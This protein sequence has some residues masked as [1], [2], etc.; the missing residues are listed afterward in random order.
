MAQSKIEWTEKSW[1]PIIGCSKVSAGCKNCY[2]ERMTYRI[3]NM[4][5]RGKYSGKAEPYGR[6]INW[7][8][9]KGNFK[10]FNGKVTLA[11]YPNLITSG[12]ESQKITFEALEGRL[13]QPLHWKKP[14]RIFVNSMSDLFHPDV[15]FEFIQNVFVVMALC[16][17]HIF[18]VL[19]KRPER[20]LQFH[21]WLI[22]KNEFSAKVLVNALRR[23]R[24]NADSYREHVEYPVPNIWLGVSVEDQKTADERIPILLQIPA[25]V[26]WLS[27]EPLL[28][29][30]DLCRSVRNFHFKNHRG[31]ESTFF[32]DELHWVVIGGESGPN[33]RPMHPDWARK[34]KI[35]CR[36][37]HVPIFI[38]QFCIK[39]KKIPFEEFPYDLKNREYPEQG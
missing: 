35:D 39:G 9:N 25:A 26:R 10:G 8:K 22:E 3:Y 16:P 20:A 17:E 31:F 15:P 7:D 12:K 6:V 19:T 11:D 33:A 18:Q 23:G 24:K 13:E 38:K 21:N 14:C 27:V 28:G 36:N 5:F 29:P 37:A 4:L 30:V 34:V 2:A 32:G 1:N